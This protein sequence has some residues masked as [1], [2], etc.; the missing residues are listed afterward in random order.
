MTA[1]GFL[2]KTTTK[3]AASAAAFLEQYREW[4]VNGE[5]AEVTN[6]IL[7]L[8]DDGKVLPTP[9]LN[10]IKSAVL[11]HIIAKDTAKAEAAIEN[12]GKTTTNKSWLC[13]IYNAKG[14]VQTRINTKNQVED[15]IKGFDLSSDADRWVDR[16]LFDG[17]SD[18]YGIVSHTR[19]NVSTTTM[20][21]D[22]IARILHKVKGPIIQ[23]KG[24]SKTLGFGVKAKEDRSTFSRG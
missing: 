18:W 16:R 22:A 5:L 1:K 6:P 21:N 10:E 12:A 4:L 8:L 14:E 2:H 13:T 7:R 19:L 20:R 3:A 23:Q 15:L 17:A 9:A 24:T 11:G